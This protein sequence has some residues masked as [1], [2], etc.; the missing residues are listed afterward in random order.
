MKD[1]DRS[2]LFGIVFDLSLN[3]AENGQ[4]NIDL[5]KEA[6]IKRIIDINVLSKIYVS[7]P[8]WLKTPRDQGESTFFVISYQEPK[9]FS[10]DSAFKLAVTVVGECQE[11]CDK[12][13]FLITDRFQTNINFQYRKGFLTNDIRGFETK[14]VV[15]DLSSSSDKVLSSLVEEY[16]GFYQ[17]LKNISDIEAFL[18]KFLNKEISN[19]R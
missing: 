8:D 9:S 6:L 11:D 14:I 1:F 10:I 4:R 19:V 16:D 17:H 7:H 15:L 5:I 13:V 12:Y 3:Y 18:N 2:V